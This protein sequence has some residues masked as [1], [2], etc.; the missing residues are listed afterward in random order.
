ML[1]IPHRN[2]CR[3]EL[4]V[5]DAP[6]KRPPLKKTTGRQLFVGIITHIINHAQNYHALSLKG[7]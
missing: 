5:D 1:V 3:N 6:F 7:S 2:H 4:S